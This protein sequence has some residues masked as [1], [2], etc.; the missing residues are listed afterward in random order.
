MFLRGSV[1][2]TTEGPQPS[3]CA[4]Q[5]VPANWFL[6]P[7]SVG[8]SGRR[9][10]IRPA[11]AP[12]IAILAG[13]LLA[14]IRTPRL[15]RVPFGANVAAEIDAGIVVGDDPGVPVRRDAEF[16]LTEVVKKLRWWQFALRPECRSQNQ[17]E[18]P[19][20][21][22]P[23]VSTTEDPNMLAAPIWSRQGPRQP[24]SAVRRRLAC[25]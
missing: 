21:G 16:E 19:G 25:Y 2:G 15:L 24:V 12:R 3:D 5:K 7:G 6:L 18:R 9:R 17:C 23:D 13:R 1:A 14:T 10:V 11:S 8:L 4:G 20:G 22:R